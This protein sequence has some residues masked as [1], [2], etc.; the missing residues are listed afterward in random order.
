M[1]SVVVSIGTGRARKVLCLG[2]AA[3]LLLALSCADRRD[4]PLDGTAVAVPTMTALPPAPAEQSPI[5]ASTATPILTPPG[6]VKPVGTGAVAPTMTALA[7]MPT[8]GSPGGAGL[9]DPLYPT[10][11]NGGYD[12]SHYIIKLNVDVQENFIS[13]STRIEAVATQGL[14]SFNVD[15]RG[16]TVLG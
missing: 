16:L 13:G 6:E 2:F 14:S 7:S 9:D 3:A 15:F 4:E 10:L 11:G 12:V 1:Y 5:S 8:T